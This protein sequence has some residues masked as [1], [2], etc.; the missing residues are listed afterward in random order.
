MKK[1]TLVPISLLLLLTA[2]ALEEVEDT[3]VDTCRELKSE[4]SSCCKDEG[5]DFGSY[6]IMFD[7]CFCKTEVE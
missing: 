6:D 7:T 4:C 3:E 5:F 2:C 1:L